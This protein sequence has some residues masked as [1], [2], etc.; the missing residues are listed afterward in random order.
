MGSHTQ[1]SGSSLEPGRRICE[2]DELA[3]V[4]LCL[5]VAVELR[6][7]EDLLEQCA[8]LD[9]G[10]RAARLDV[11]EHT[12]EVAHARRE[13][14]HLAEA[15]L[16][17]LEPFADQLE[18]LAQP[19]LERVVEFLVDGL[20]HLLELLLVALLQL[21]D[22]RVDGRSDQLERPRVGLAELL[23][24]R[25]HP[26]QLGSLHVAESG[27]VGRERGVRRPQA[28][29]PAPR[30]TRVRRGRPPLGWRGTPREEASSVFAAAEGRTEQ[31]DEQNGVHHGERQ[32]DQH[33]G[34]GHGGAS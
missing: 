25:V 28:R 27:E 34:L 24:L 18:R 21:F 10:P 17:R 22:A 3:G 13:V 32:D 26:V 12:L 19:L 5:H 31:D 20:A 30:A 8:Q 6:G 15:T 1:V 7:R 11:R 14:L 2:F 9:F 16:D 23:Q 33:D 4:F 29:H